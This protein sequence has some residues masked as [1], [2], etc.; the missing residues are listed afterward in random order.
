MDWKTKLKSRKLWTTLIGIV[1][2]VGA[3]F[4]LSE[5][6][7]TQVVAIISAGGIA[8]TYIFG[9]SNIDSARE[10][11]HFNIN[12]LSKAEVAELLKGWMEVNSGE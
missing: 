10:S 2:L 9:E 7:V 11:N 3:S 6:V 8:I 4:G 5:A 1:T 12:D